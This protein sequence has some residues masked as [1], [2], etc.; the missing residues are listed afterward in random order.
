MTGLEFRCA[1]SILRARA[2]LGS[3]GMSE[4]AATSKEQSQPARRSAWGRR[5]LTREQRA[6]RAGR[7]RAYLKLF[8]VAHFVTYATVCT[9]VLLTTGFRPFLSSPRAGGS[10]SCCT[11]SPR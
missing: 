3:L 4:S 1:P 2:P 7:R 8:F 10:G 6:V 9:A 11:S 5:P